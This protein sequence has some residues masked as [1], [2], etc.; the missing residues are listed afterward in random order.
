[1]VLKTIFVWWWWF[2]PVNTITEYDNRVMSE[3]DCRALADDLNQR[4]QPTRLFG[5]TTTSECVKGE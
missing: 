3:I 1:M 2:M 5:V 4:G